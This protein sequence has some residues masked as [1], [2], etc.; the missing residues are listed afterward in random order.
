MNEMYEEVGG[1]ANP[2]RYQGVEQTVSDTSTTV[3]NAEPKRKKAKSI[4]LVIAAAV[5]LS[6]LTLSLVAVVVYSPLARSSSQDNVASLQMKIQQLERQVEKLQVIEGTNIT[7]EQL[8]V[9]QQSQQN[10]IDQLM[11]F[12][13]SA[14]SQLISVQSLLQTTSQVQTNTVDEL[15]TLRTVNLYENCIEETRTCTIPQSSSTY[16]W[17]SCSTSGLLINRSVSTCMY[18]IVILDI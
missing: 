6:L 3:K 16:Y 7:V 18:Y 10:R 17:R 1:R 2:N 9:L 11:N 5:L 8:I 13:T 12:E 14:T 4:F 15:S